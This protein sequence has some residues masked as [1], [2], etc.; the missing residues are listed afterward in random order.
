MALGMIFAISFITALSGALMPGPLLTVTIAQTAKKGF[1]ASV[2]LMVGHSI[3]E[4]LLVIGLWFGLGSFM[5][6]HWIMGVIT[7]LGG[8]MLL[9][10]GYGMIKDSRN[11][12]FELKSKSA[13]TK[14]QGLLDNPIIA[15]MVVSLSNPYWAIWWATI[16]LTLFG[17]LSQNAVPVIIAFFLGHIS[18][19]FTWYLAVGGAV[20][21][22]R[23]FIKPETYKIV[24]QICGIFLIFLGGSFIYLLISGQLWNISMDSLGEKVQSISLK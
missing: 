13:E 9:W 20:S 16:G 2:L 19:D 23:K 12:S 7:G 21:T 8:L 17:A 18:G 24:V 3:L 22:G 15:G 5:K 4:L 6:V 14:K 10:M 11:V 1:Y